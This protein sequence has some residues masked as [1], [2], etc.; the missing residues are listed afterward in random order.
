[1]L[2]LLAATDAELEKMVGRWYI[3]GREMR[4][5]RRNALVVLGN[6]ADPADGAVEE[7]LR[8]ALADADPILQ[9][10]AVWAAARLGRPDLIAGIAGR[11][12][13][14]DPIVAE[15]LARVGQ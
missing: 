12:G 14:L 10:H 6:V 2:R 1:V 9:A 11:R 7:V 4:Y 13:D 3:P 8:R 15:E 5:V